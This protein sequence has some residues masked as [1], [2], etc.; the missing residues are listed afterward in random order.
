MSL[1][2]R[3]SIARIGLRTSIE[4]LADSTK[5][6]LH[7][8]NDSLRDELLANSEYIEEQLRELKSLDVELLA[9]IDEDDIEKDVVESADFAAK[10]R[11]LLAKIKSKTAVTPIIHQ[12]PTVPNQAPKNNFVKLPF[13]HVQKFGGDPTEWSSFWDVFASAIDKNDELEPVQKF[14]YLRS[15]LY[16]DAARAIDGFKPTNETYFEAVRLLHERFGDKQVIIS[17]HMNKFKELKEVK[18]MANVKELRNL[19]D[20]VESNVRSLESVGI[21]MDTYGTFITPEILKLLPQELRIVVTRKLPG[22]WDLGLLLQVLKEELNV[23]EKCMFAFAAT[24][25]EKK[26]EVCT[27]SFQPSRAQRNLATASAL[28]AGARRNERNQSLEKSSTVACYFCNKEH[29]SRN[30]NVVTDHRARRDILRQLGRCF[31]CMR[32]GH[33][34]R[35]CRSQF[36]CY[37]C[38]G[39]HHSA[40][41]NAYKAHAESPKPTVSNTEEPKAQ[42]TTNIHISSKTSVLLQTA[43]AE[44]SSPDNDA[45]K[46]VVRIVFD[47]GSQK[48]YVTQKLKNELNLKVVGRERLLIK[49]FGDERPRMRD[50]DIVQIAVK[51]L[52]GI[53]VYISAYV[54]PTICSPISNQI[55]ALAVD[56]YPHLRGL[57]LADFQAGDEL[58]IEKPSEILIGNDMFWLLV[59]DEIIRGNEANGPVAMKS[60]LGYIV[61]GP[62]DVVSENGTFLSQVMRVETSCVEEREADPL[63]HEIKKFWEVESERGKFL[64][65]TPS[66][67]DQFEADIAFVDGKYQCKMPFKEEH[68][69]L[70][71]N[72][73]VA[74]SRLNSLLCRLK[75]NP[76]VAKEYDNVIKDQL[77]KG[78][79]EKVDLN[80]P[81]E[82][83]KVSYLPHKMVIREDKDTTK[84]RVVFDASAKKDGPSLNE[85]LNAGPALLPMLV[86][87]LMRFRLNKVVLLGDIEKAFLN[88]SID[89]SQRNYL[90]FLWVENIESD[91]PEIVALRFTS[92]VFGVICSPYLLNA[93]IRHHLELYQETDPD[94]VENVRSSLYCD[95]YVSSFENETEAFE[96]YEKLKHCFSDAGFNMRK[97]KSNSKSLIDKIEVNENENVSKENETKTEVSSK[98]E[99]EADS[100]K[101]EKVLGIS[102]NREADKLIFEFEKIL[103]N[104]D[105][106]NVTKRTILS[107]VAKFFD[108]LGVIAPVILPLKVL[109]QNVCKEKC[110]W[111]TPMNDEIKET[112]LKI[113]S[114][115]RKTGNIEFERA[116]L[117]QEISAESIESIA[118]HGFCDASTIGYGACVYI[119]YKLKDGRNISSLVAAKTRVAPLEGQTIPRMELLAALLL[120]KLMN[121]VRETLKGSVTI[122][123]TFCWSD[124]QI[125]LFWLAN[126]N[127]TLKTFVQNR[128]IEIRKLAPPEIWKYCPTKENPADV[129]SR[130]GTA[131]SIRDS[132]KWWKGPDF[133]CYDPENWPNHPNFDNF[134]ENIERVE[135]K[136]VEPD[137]VFTAK[138]SVE[139]EIEVMPALIDISKYSDISKLLRIVAYVKRF[140]DNLK[141]KIADKDPFR[142]DLNTEEIANARNYLIKSEQSCL[143][144]AKYF[145][146]LQHNLRL[147]ED[148]NGLFVKGTL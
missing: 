67:E 111:D 137:S 17:G 62:V 21:S 20:K 50:C 128:V 27:P 106:E 36:G 97:W 71:D 127:K 38:K 72:Y 61:S 59:E 78:I 26:E 91:E 136:P 121:N 19:Y 80:E 13:L 140:V 68:P 60:K 57:Q 8:Y 107:T 123:E 5:V 145:A 10:H 55:L 7:D 99:N 63:I 43:R 130:G 142:G 53:L 95:D 73:T 102:W 147:F 87:I 74:K 117:D 120:A 77:E 25:T 110:D 40:I 47:S 90:R 75:A 119:V 92:A 48:S 104:V 45:E 134:A 1:L 118:L 18:S 11:V 148:E 122:T 28:Y 29:L 146:E 35:D 56:K 24:P 46:A 70:P 135:T 144:D 82:V 14:N 133:L 64:N 116:Y 125:V 12:T 132:K 101:P 85:C 33:R 105:E 41:C 98:C 83:G 114:D 81:T 124:S 9:F 112:F 108:P 96:Q 109:F 113:I 88:V 58:S 15:Y 131:L 3:K 89:P 141:A 6:L 34:A 84:L 86:D 76:K 65:E 32:T 79:V 31:V 49:A 103:E 100:P 16:G 51:T 30:C 42:T 93:T 126:T 2:K 44:I 37:N 4:K 129:A 69:L 39:S 138:I 54:V 139:K 66:I 23:R 52:D 94:F 143:R 22:T 115:L